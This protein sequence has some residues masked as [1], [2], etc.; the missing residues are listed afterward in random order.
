MTTSLNRLGSANT[1]DTA[2]N[3]ITAR[4]SALSNLQANLTS[5]KKIVLASDDPTGAAQ[6]ERAMTRISRIAT[7]QRA[8]A[9]QRDS[10]AQAESTLGDVTNALQSFR[11]LVVSAG[12][13]TQ[14]AADRQTVAL[15]LTQLRDQIF[16]LSNTK[17]N[18]G[19]PLF[20]ALGSAL[21]PF[22]GPSTPPQDYTFN[23]LA[24]QT[25][26]SEVSIPSSLDGDSAFMLQAARDGA[27]NVRLS[28][29]PASRT[30]ATSN[31][32]VTNSTLVTGAAYAIT[33][34][35]IDT[36]STPGMTSVT[37]DVTA[38]PPG[39]TTSQ[40][41]P[42]Y[43]SAQTANIS[44]AGMPGLSL[45]VTGTPAIGDS[46]TITPSPSIFSV[47]DNAIRDIGGASS[48]AAATQA[49]SQ[50]L[51]N[52]DIGMG[53]VSAARGQA[54]ALLNRAD[55]ISSNQDARSLQLEADQSNAEGLD[56]VKGIS[57]FQNAQTGYQTALQAY[58]QVQKLSLFNYIS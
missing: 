57:D 58:A 8:L 54:G 16:G 13:G 52:I 4:Q 3:N 55:S 56:M 2:I 30:L 36:V 19:Q 51:G 43:L 49:V 34:T 29:I 9:S 27:Y 15:Q 47:M 23:G 7:D 28:A 35:G 37:Y 39:T 31:V 17:D 32:A 45:S 22:V 26:S 25:S 38:T 50:A 33:I 40:T 24:G 11:E 21:A 14:T 18:N 41:A 20:S 12:N 48:S 46:V 53:R 6:A 10:I 5:G 42:N 44:V 1:Y